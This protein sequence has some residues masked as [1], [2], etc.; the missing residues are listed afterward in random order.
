MD[1]AQISFDRLR[2]WYDDKPWMM[3]R[4]DRMESDLDRMRL[5]T[6]YA[7]V[8]YIR[9]GIEYESY[10]KEYAAYRKLKPEEL[11]SILDELQESARNFRTYRQWFDHIEEYRKMLE[12]QKGK[13]DDGDAVVLSTMHSSKG[14][15]FPE[16]FI[17]D[18]NEEVI[19]HQKA[20]L[21]ADIEE[22]RRLFY[23]GMTRAKERLHLFYLKER[24]GRKL[25]SS[26]FLEVFDIE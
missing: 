19:P 1:T 11:I 25:D 26:R 7:A 15:E 18:I 21:E 5:M 4:I 8:N 6:P 20:V 24:Y 2:T 12:E 9:N 16:V 22:E 17:L 3:E 14:L 13:T 10:L 23:V